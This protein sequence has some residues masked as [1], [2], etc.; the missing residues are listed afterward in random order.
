MKR[1]LGQ[2]AF[3]YIFFI[4]CFQTI[5]SYTLVYE[6]TVSKLKSDLAG[7]A[8]RV[9]QDLNFNNGKWDLS[10]YLADPLTPHPTGSSGFIRPLYIASTEGF[11]IERSNPISGL[12]DASDMKH[13]LQFQTIQTLTTVTNEKWRVLSK[14][15]ILN[16]TTIG[17]I[18]ASYFSPD[19]NNLA[20]IDTKL[21]T[22]LENVNMLLKI[23]PRTGLIDPGAVDI[24]RINYDVSFEVVNRYNKTLINNGRTP[25]FIDTS[26]LI[27]EIGNKPYTVLADKR[28]GEP[29]L[30]HRLIMLSNNQP[31]G[32]IVTADSMKN[33]FSLLNTY[34]LISVLSTLGIIVPLGYITL[35]TFE[36]EITGDKGPSIKS[37]DFDKKKS[38]LTIDATTIQIPYAS[39]QY[40][41]LDA[42]FSNSRKR[43]END[44]LLEKLGEEEMGNSR[45][46][47]DAM[48]A[49]NKKANI[50]L[51]DYQD[52]TYKINP[53]YL[54]QLQKE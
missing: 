52:R 3:L 33:V 4:I 5:L 24:R 51:I 27:D 22:T 31:I 53:S 38:T 2:K 49:V 16:N 36:R 9:E 45:V 8:R 15:V 30:I 46:V 37:I 44:E 43:W 21:F 28:T 34:L 13:L 7:Y 17:V 11:V 10:H 20:Q 25:S 35:K 19:P 39:N 23:D 40:Y 1:R 47:Y 26:Y 50:K 32:L 41:I 54:K 48:I 42:L 6:L 18:T 29:F 12:L 14:P